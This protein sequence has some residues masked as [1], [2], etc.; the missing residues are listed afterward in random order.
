MVE[1]SPESLREAAGE[2]NGL[3]DQ[4]R[5]WPELGAAAAARALPSTP[6]CQ[7]LTSADQVTK[8]AFAVLGAR[9]REMGYLLT[10]SANA[11]HG[12]DSEA[13]VRLSAMGDLNPS[14]RS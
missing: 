7:A 11:Y 8:D 13:A 10:T 1:V 2:L 3:A 5:T 6:V 9:F 14:A 12:T 4:A